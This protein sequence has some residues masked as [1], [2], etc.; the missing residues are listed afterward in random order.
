MEG[1]HS[2]SVDFLVS[3]NPLSGAKNKNSLGSSFDIVFEKAYIYDS[4]ARSIRL[5]ILETELYFNMP[6]V[7]AEYT[8]QTVRIIGPNKTTNAA[9][10]DNS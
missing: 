8:N 2:T 7:G 6:N 9:G 3:S 1:Y 10:R 5:E 4:K